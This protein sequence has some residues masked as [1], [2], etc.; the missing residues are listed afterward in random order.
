MKKPTNNYAFVDSQNVN[1][2]I[3]AL[4]WKLDWRRFRV[5][6]EEKYG[7]AKAYLFI[8]FMPENQQLYTSLQ[9]AGFILVFKPV[10]RT[11][12]RDAKGNV[13]ADLVLR[14]MTDYA[15][16]DKAIIVTSDG[17]FYS[18][19]EYLYLKRKLETVLSP[20][21]ANCSV[22]LKRTAKERITFMETLSISISMRKVPMSSDMIAPEASPSGST[23]R[24]E[25]LRVRG[26][27]PHVVE[28]QGHRVGRRHLHQL[29]P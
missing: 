25:Q 20:G 22:L 18:L 4:G 1:L 23:H 24:A 5:Y 17:D 28:Q 27:A 9:Q 16:Y 10:L 26:V 3:Q 15:E 21:S 29:T 14:A 6:L 2:G 7:V 8:G 12:E 11:K 19:V 13:D